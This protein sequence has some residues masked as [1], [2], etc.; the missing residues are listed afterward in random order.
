MNPQ[1]F[2]IIR[3]EVLKFSGKSDKQPVS[4]YQDVK[5]AHQTKRSGPGIMRDILFML[6]GVFSAGFGLKGFL[7]PNGFIDGGI[8]GISLLIHIESTIPLAGLIIF[9]NLPFVLLGWQQ[10]SSIFSIKSIIAISLLAFVV[11]VVP[12]PV[13]TSDKLLVSVFG[14]FFLGVGIGLTIRGGGVID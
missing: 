2:N 3:Q 11:A 9:I 8:T 4:R 5:K 1:F 10:I 7:I 13:V 12:Y 14:G 6:T